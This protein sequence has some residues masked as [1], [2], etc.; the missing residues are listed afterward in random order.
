MPIFLTGC[1]SSTSKTFWLYTSKYL[2]NPSTFN[3][4]HHPTPATSSLLHCFWISSWLVS[5][6]LPCSFTDCLPPSSQSGLV[7]IVSFLCL[8]APGVSWLIWST[9]QA[10]TRSSVFFLS[11]SLRLNS[12]SFLPGVLSCNHTGLLPLCWTP[13]AGPCLRDFALLSSVKNAL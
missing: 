12:P 11:V 13:T 2:Q 4:L 8:K 1:L 7:T 9:G 5:V 10:P 6:V 3:H